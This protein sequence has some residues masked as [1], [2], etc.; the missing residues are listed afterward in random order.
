M[1]VALKYIGE[2]W[3]IPSLSIQSQDMGAVTGSFRHT[4]SLT[5]FA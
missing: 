5:Q 4:L 3:R 2:R 1:L